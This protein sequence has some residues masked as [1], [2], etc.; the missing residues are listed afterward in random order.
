MNFGL[1]YIQNS[2]DKIK[3]Q[4]FPNNQTEKNVYGIIFYKDAIIS[5]DLLAEI[6]LDTH[7]YEKYNI[8][9]NVIW[10]NTNPSTKTLSQLLNIINLIEY[11]IFNGNYNFI[12]NCQNNKNKFNLISEYKYTEKDEYKKIIIKKKIIN[13]LDLLSDCEFIQIERLRAITVKNNI[14]NNIKNKMYR[15]D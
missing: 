15:I 1:N 12:E 10:L 13:L 6:S 5:T 14:K 8:I 3:A 7:D 4:Y 11:L 2:L 9:T